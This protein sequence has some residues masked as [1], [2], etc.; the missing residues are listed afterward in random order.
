MRR[1]VVVLPALVTLLA[2][3]LL[4]HPVGASAGQ[5]VDMLG[6]RLRTW[7]VYAFR[8]WTIGTF[9]VLFILPYLSRR[10]LRTLRLFGA[11]LVLVY[12]QLLV[13]NNTERLLVLAFP[14]FVLMSLEGLRHRLRKDRRQYD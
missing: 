6:W 12:A 8:D 13:A 1:A 4:I 5:G 3:R 14:V 10:N 9:G 11:F 7:D 2:L